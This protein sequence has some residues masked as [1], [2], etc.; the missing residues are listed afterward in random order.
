V[1]ASGAE[2]KI[3]IKVGCRI[4][5]GLWFL[6]TICPIRLV[7]GEENLPQLIK[8]IEPSIVVILTYDAEKRVIGQGSGFLSIPKGM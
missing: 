3:R 7:Y 6:M 1:G 5:I 4:I 8:K 2:K